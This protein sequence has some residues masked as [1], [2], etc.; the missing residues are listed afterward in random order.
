M[1][2]A[3]VKICGMSDV[4]MVKHAVDCGVDAIG[5]IFFE[6][7][8][9]NVS[10]VKAKEIRAVVPPFVT[11][12]GVFV[13]ENVNVVNDISEQVGLDLIQLHGDEDEEYAKKLN[14]SY[15]KAIRV[16][17]DSTI[18]TVSRVHHS[19]RGFLLDAYH[20]DNYGGTGERFDLSFIPVEMQGSAIIA[21][22]ITPDNVAEVL[23]VQPYAIDVKN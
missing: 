2:R 7:S 6:K 19:A 5:L 15:I 4:S 3:R 1:S 18:L 17:D 9:R 23:S 13:N 12:V 16:K 10:V 22:G 14:L 20:K 21:G 11:L 8:P